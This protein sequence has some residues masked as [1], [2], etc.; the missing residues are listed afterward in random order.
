MR[1]SP[2]I[3]GAIRDPKRYKQMID[4]SGF[5]F[6]RRISPMDID[7]YVELGGREIILGEF[8]GPGG[9]VHRGQRKALTTLAIAS[10]IAGMEVLAFIAFHDAE[11]DD[12]AQ[13]HLAKVAEIL[14]PSVSRCW[15]SPSGNDRR[16]GELID[17]WRVWHRV[18]GNKK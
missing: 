11:P 1:N 15:R 12:I 17:S 4:F 18:H 13:G 14:C 5:Q 8:K 9:K 3:P 16:V 7:F 2:I 6:E 10:H